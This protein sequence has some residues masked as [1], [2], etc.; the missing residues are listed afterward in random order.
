MLPAG[1]FE[2]SPSDRELEQLARSAA[3]T[4]AV[5]PRRAECLEPGNRSLRGPCTGS[6]FL[7]T[8][9]L[10][11]VR[12]FNRGGIMDLPMR[13]VNHSGRNPTGLLSSLTGPQKLSARFSVPR[14]HV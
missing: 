6:L 11:N 14:P 9:D 2:G 5:N 7:P 12:A 1:S 13:L 3:T 8:P 10:A 4:T